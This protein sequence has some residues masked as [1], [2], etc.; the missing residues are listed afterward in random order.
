MNNDCESNTESDEDRQISI[1]IKKSSF[2]KRSMTVDS[3]A[4][5]ETRSTITIGTACSKKQKIL[6]RKTIDSR[7]HDHEKGK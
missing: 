2:Q 3:P 4:P 7:S 5:G 1:K 6:K